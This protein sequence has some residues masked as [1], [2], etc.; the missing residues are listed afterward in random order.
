MAA[1]P[2]Y[3]ET[4]EE[5]PEVIERIRRTSGSDVRLVLPAR[6]RLGQSR[7][8]FQLLKQYANQLGKRVAIITADPA[9]QLMAEE[10]GFPAY[11]AIDQYG[12][13]PAGTV[14]PT[15]GTAAV[16]AAAVTRTPTPIPTNATPTRI[17]VVQSRLQ[18]KAATEIKPGRFLLYFGSLAVLI[19]GVVGLAIYVPSAQVTLVATAT[20][21][22]V[23]NLQV[24]AAPGTPPVRVRTAAESKQTSGTFK[25]TG[26]QSTPATIS[27]GNVTINQNC[28]AFKQITIPLGTR[29]NSTTGLQYALKSDVNLGGNGTSADAPVIATQPGAGGNLPAGAIT[30][31]SSGA[32]APTCLLVFNT[33]A[34]GGGAD[35]LKKVIIQQSDY[36]AARSALEQQ[37]RGQIADDLGKQVSAGEKLSDAIQFEAPDFATDH[38]VG[39]VV[40]GFNG[41]MTL[42]AEGA[43]YSPDDVGKAFTAALQKKLSPGQ[44]LIPNKNVATYTVTGNAGGLLSFKGSANGFTAPRLDVERVKSRLVARTLGQAKADLGKLP[45]VSSAQ[46]KESP[47]RLPIMPLVSSRISLTYDIR[48]GAVAPPKTG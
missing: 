8:N 10:S 26:V 31:F 7:F 48:Q 29:L 12:V 34:M 3:I 9:V 25:A 23:E 42:K 43:Y 19:V 22:S 14:A 16:A 4:E 13:V 41:T 46:I 11:N 32:G 24:D 33:S 39:E 30:S 5:I 37:L 18:S 28:P 45:G 17:K 38:K 27:I 44:E 15:E 1:N 36:E 21:F 40:G 47:I 2:I 35:E 20:P 6:S